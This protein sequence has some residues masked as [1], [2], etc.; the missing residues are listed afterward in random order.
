MSRD[1]ARAIVRRQAATFL[2]DRYGE[3]ACGFCNGTGRDVLGPCPSCRGT[4]VAEPYPPAEGSD[5]TR[6]EGT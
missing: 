3:F 4:G 2:G 5:D 1:A 6:E